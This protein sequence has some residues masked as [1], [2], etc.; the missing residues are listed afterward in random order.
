MN[1]TL[2]VTLGMERFID[3]NQ[4]PSE[5]FGDTSDVLGKMLNTSV[6]CHAV[7]C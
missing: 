5:T 4:C 1:V 2:Q 3:L 7:P 6:I